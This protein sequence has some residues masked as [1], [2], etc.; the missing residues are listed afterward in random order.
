MHAASVPV[1]L[2]RAAGRSRHRG[3]RGAGLT[4]PADE[5]TACV[6][7]SE[8]VLR[9]VG[10]ER[11]VQAS[12]EA[13]LSSRPPPAPAWGDTYAHAQPHSQTGRP[14]SQRATESR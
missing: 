9:L 12:R 10:S 7:H 5:K 13:A 6:A 8:F 1:A 14:G 2:Q 11:G 3:R 4:C